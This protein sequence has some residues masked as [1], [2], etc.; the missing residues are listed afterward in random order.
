MMRQTIQAIALSTSAVICTEDTASD[1]TV[2][3]SFAITSADASNFNISATGEVT[4]AIDFEA[5]GSS[6]AITH[7]HLTLYIQIN[8]RCFHRK[9]DSSC[10]ECQRRSIYC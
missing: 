6:Q 7:T 4:A 1:G 10:H 5:N 9:R 8:R 3:G 2:R